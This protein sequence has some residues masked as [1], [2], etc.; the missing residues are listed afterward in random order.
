M[1]VELRPLAEIKPYEKNPR[2]N[3]QAVDAVAES[4]RRFGFRQPIVVDGDGVIVCGHTR[5]KAARKLGLEKVPVH[6]AK[7][8]TPEQIRAYRIADNKTAELAE[9]N[10]ELLPIELLELQGMGLDWSLLGFDADELAKMLDTDVKEGLTD[11]DDIPAPPDEATTQVGDLW[12][13][14]DH[15]LLC[16]DSSRPEDVDRLLDGQPVHLVNTDPPYNVKVEPRSNN[17]IAAGLSS[18]PAAESG[19]NGKRRGLTHHQGFDLARGHSKARKTTKQLR[20]KDRPLANDFVTDE[21]FD[22]MLDAWFGNMARVLESG[23]SFYIW[24]GYANLGNYPPFLKKH[25]LYF[26]QG[27]VWDKQHPVLTRKDFMGAFEICFYGW[28]EGAGHAFFGPNNV[29]DL[30]H[31][32][33]VNPQSMI[34]LTEKPVELA[35]RAMQYSS[36]VGENVLDLFGG[37]GSTLIAAEQTQ[38]RAYLMELD[39]LYCDVIVKRWE[40]FTGKSAER[41][42]S[43]EV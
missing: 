12:V 40:Q 32:K 31:V 4:I 28:R 25:G 13:L 37:S 30:W 9:W 15:R 24:G 22:A 38:R 1:Q 5:W 18:F 17:A 35:V 14:G 41:L 23:R 19:A 42:C 16:A 8:L 20:A 33:K 11:P 6:V 27:I 29:T 39:P 10:L 21:A 36:R 43:A 26:S 3:D 34:H 2:A 7:D